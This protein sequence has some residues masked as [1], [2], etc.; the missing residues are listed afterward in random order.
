MLGADFDPA[1]MYAWAWDDFHVLR[2]DIRA[3]CEQILPGAPF[4][5][6]LHLLDTDPDRAVHGVEAYR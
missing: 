5:E 6:V 4:A 2:A 3:T 1:E